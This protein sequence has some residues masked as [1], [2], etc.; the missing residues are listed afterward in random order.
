MSFLNIFAD[1]LEIPITLVYRIIHIGTYSMYI[2]Y[3]QTARVYQT[4]LLD[5]NS[6]GENSS[7]NIFLWFSVTVKK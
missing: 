1:F 3:F 4:E 6:R 5:L 2:M 7:S